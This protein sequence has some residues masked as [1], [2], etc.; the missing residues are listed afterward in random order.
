MKN[1]MYSDE[2]LREMPKSDLHLHLDGS[3]RLGSMV[4]MAKT[5]GVKLPSMSEAGLKEKVYKESYAN[6]GEY[7]NGFQYT[8]SILREPENMERAAYELAWDNIAEGVCYIEVRFAPQLLMDLSRGI[9]MEEVL[10]RVDKGLRKARTE[11]NNSANVTEEGKPAFHYGIISCAMRMFGAKG[12]SPYY[13]NLFSMARYLRPTQ[14]VALAAQEMVRGAVKLRDDKGLPIA[15]IDLAGQEDGYPAQDFKEAYEFAHRHF[16]HKTVHAGEAYGAESIF[17]AIT[18]CH[19][20][21]IGHGYS[22]FMPELIQDPSIKDKARYIKDLASFVAD[23]RTTVEV[24]LTSNLQTNPAIKN[25]KEHK[26]KDMLENRI[27]TSLCTDNRLVSN[28]TVTKEYRLATD[29]FDIP[30]KRL[31]DIVAYGFKKSFY[32]GSYVEK[33]QY[34]KKN[35]RYFDKVAIKHGVTPQ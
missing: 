32:P 3:L 35:M 16:M 13:T 2:F 14:V 1:K 15:G 24:C 31:K 4:E 21:R 12:F 17:Q 11:Y 29:N 26:F 33:R 6:L 34:A 9:D 23:R 8:C 5:C 30:L 7:L 25:I 18:E 22:L 19:A 10:K 20:D 28:T 27:A